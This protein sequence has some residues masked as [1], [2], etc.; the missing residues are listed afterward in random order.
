THTPAPYGYGWTVLS[1]IPYFLGVG[2]FLTT[3]LAFKIFSLGG[4]LLTLVYFLWLQKRGT[5]RLN[6][7][8]LLSFC[9]SPLILL[10]SIGNAHND[11]WMMLPAVAGLVLAFQYSTQKKPHQVLLSVLLIVISVSIKWA[12]LVIVPLWLAMVVFGLYWPLSKKL[13]EQLREHWAV[14]ASLLMFIPLLT[15]RSQQFHPWYLLWSLVWVPLFPVKE[16]LFS[17]IVYIALM[18]FSVSSLYRYIPWIDAGGFSADVILHQ[19]LITW[20][21]GVFIAVV[22]F[23]I[24]SKIKRLPNK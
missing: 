21:G 14:I 18:A 4:V 11:I 9:L 3:W 2:K 7:L 1:L 10:E 15:E 16:T 20:L 17:R 13:Y 6:K 19:K 12:T 8:G 24:T 23:S 22:W 5:V